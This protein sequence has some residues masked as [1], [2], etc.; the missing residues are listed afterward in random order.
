MTP[1][2]HMFSDG[3]VERHDLVQYFWSQRTVAGLQT[4]LVY[5]ADVC[6]LTTPS[7]AHA[8]YLEGRDEVLLDID[9]RFEYLPRFRRFDIM[10]PQPDPCEKFSII[11]VDPPFFYIPMEKIREAVLVVSRGRTDVPL[12]IGFLKR[13]EAS[14]M[15]AFKDFGIRETKF[16]LEYA[17]VKPNKWKNYALYSNIDLPG[18]KRIKHQKIR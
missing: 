2:R 4:A 18:I 12:L 17:T 7:L 1:T 11:V 16:P 13:E 10:D 8:W 9:E 15:Q 14:L 6:C 5:E 3:F